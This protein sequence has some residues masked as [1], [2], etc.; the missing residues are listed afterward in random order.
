MAP[1]GEG[2][3][4]RRY[5]A[6]LIA[7][8]GLGGCGLAA[9]DPANISQRGRWQR[10]FR[11]VNLV[12]NDIWLEREDAPF[13]LPAEKTEAPGCVEPRLRSI[14]Q[15]NALMPVRE[16]M[17]CTFETIDRQEGRIAGAGKCGPA[18]RNG[19]EIFGTIDLEGREKPDRVAAKIGM[20]LVV[21]GRQ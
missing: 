19:F 11:P 21:R 20:S 5:P 10:E 17:S 14:E 2:K 8:A 9:D 3:T 18:Q 7:L 1:R 16:G 13:E 12:A 15:I 4:M 6:A